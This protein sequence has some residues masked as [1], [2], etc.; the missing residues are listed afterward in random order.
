MASRIGNRFNATIVDL[1][2]LTEVDVTV[3]VMNNFYVS[4][5]SDIQNFKTEAGCKRFFFSSCFFLYFNVDYLTD[6]VDFE[7]FKSLRIHAVFMGKWSG[8]GSAF[9]SF[10]KS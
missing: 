7:S 6:L 1:L 4:Q 5:P 10:W 9:A 3:A 8:F 2:P